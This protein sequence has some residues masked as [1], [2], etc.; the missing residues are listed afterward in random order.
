MKN[1]L[2][3]ILSLC[4]ILLALR[5]LSIYLTKGTCLETRCQRSQNSYKEGFDVNT[6]KTQIS[7]LNSS[8]K[9]SLRDY[10]VM[11]SYNSCSDGNYQN[12]KVSIDNLKSVLKR[13]VRFL[14]FELFS[15]DD[16]TVVSVTD[17]NDFNYKSA[18]NELPIHKV[19]TEVRNNGMYAGTSPNPSDPLFLHFRIKSKIPRVYNEL[20][21]ALNSVFGKRLLSNAN[22]GKVKSIKDCETERSKTSAFEGC[23]K[24]FGK[25]PIDTLRNKVVILVNGDSNIYSGREL[26]RLTNIVTG[27]EITKLE[28]NYNVE[29]ETD[30]KTLINFNKQNMTVTTPDLGKSNSPAAKKHHMY[31]C[32]FV[33]MNFGKSSDHLEYYLNLFNKEG[34]AFVEKPLELRFIPEK[35]IPV[36]EIPDELNLKKTTTKSF[37]EATITI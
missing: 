18:S 34:K 31:G 37:P 30:E 32:Q 23:G 36:K 29:Y 7:G 13:G 22:P 14:D 25:V 4:V 15:V 27:T 17:T 12:G 9:G 21:R 11:S 20:A 3:I 6:L 5:Y 26:H 24:N 1:L 2:L 19:L 33:C 28:Y 10:Y 8:A 16:K 35:P